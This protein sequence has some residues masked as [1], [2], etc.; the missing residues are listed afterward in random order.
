[1]LRDYLIPIYEAKVYRLIRKESSNL[2]D[3]FIASSVERAIAVFR[4]MYKKE[5]DFIEKIADSYRDVE[6][7]YYDLIKDVKN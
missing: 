6:R 3:I 1:M 7:D 2:P 5:P 4:E